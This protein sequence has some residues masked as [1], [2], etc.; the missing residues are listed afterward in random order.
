MQVTS[1]LPNLSLTIFSEMTQLAEAHGAIN[2]SQGLQD[3]AVPAELPALV[4][5]YMQRGNSLVLFKVANVVDA[6]KIINATVSKVIFLWASANRF[7]FFV[8]LNICRD[9]IICAWG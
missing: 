2:L 1:K 5:K 9:A 8:N 4:A 3:Y 7:I 6:H